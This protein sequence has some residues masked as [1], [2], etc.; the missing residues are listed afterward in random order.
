MALLHLVSGYGKLN[1]VQYLIER[2]GNLDVVDKDGKTAL[3][4][5]SEK[6]HLNVVQLLI[7]K[8]AAVDTKDL[9][10]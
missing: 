8:G 6:G 1:I 4:Y 7:E 10:L 9:Y 5:A 2:G 3:H